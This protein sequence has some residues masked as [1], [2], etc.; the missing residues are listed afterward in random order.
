M[1]R[2]RAGGPLSTPGAATPAIETLVEAKQR[3]IEQ[4][5]RDWKGGR[6]QPVP[7]E[8]ESIPLPEE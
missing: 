4:A 7:G 8:T 6:F 3:D 2:A 1:S 5:K